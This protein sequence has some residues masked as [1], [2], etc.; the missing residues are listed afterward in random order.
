MRSVVSKNLFSSY[1]VRNLKEV[2]I[3]QYA[4]DTLFFGDVTQHNV[5][6]LK[7]ILRC[8]EK[9]SGL[10]INFSK[11]HLGCLGKSGSWCRAAAQFLNCSHMDFPFSYLGIPIGVSSKSWSVWQPIIRKFEDKLAKWKQRSLSMG[12]RITLINSVLTALPIYLLSFFKIPKKVVHKIVSIQRKFLWG[13]Q[14][15]ASKIYWVKWG[16]GW[17]LANNQNQPWARILI[18]KYG[19]W[20]ELITGGKS[21]F[22]S[23]WWQHLKAIF[24]QQHTNYFDD[25][26]KWRE[27]LASAIED[28]VLNIMWSLKIP[29]RASAFS[30]RLF[31]NRLPTR[32]NLRRRQVS[33][34][35]YSCPLC[36]L[37]EESVNHLFFNCSKTRSLWWEPMRWVNRVGPFP[38]DP[39][40]HFLQFSQWNRPSYTVK[41]WEFLWIALSVSIWHYRNGMIFKN[42]P[43]NPEKVMD[44]ALFHTWSWLKCVEK[45]FQ[46][47]FNFWSTNLKE[48][49]S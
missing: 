21:K 35:T 47:H 3:L 46:S 28:R 24:Q 25:N 41:R 14:Q 4:D 37:E 26:L 30:W 43:F 23:Q 5:R 31:K 33:L 36:D 2:N 44:E 42:Q 29:P 39:K 49:F 22:H 17:E 8:F 40:N 34:H 38:T 27:G 7:C 13:G 15:E 20:N 1:Q 12:G 9:A 18:S 48:A 19:G 6:T 16:T 10:K 11:S 32:D 45:G